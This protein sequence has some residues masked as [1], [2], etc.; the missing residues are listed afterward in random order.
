MNVYLGANAKAQAICFALCLAA[1]LVG[2]IFALLFL[3]KANPIERALTDLFACALIGGA[4]YL[5]VEFIMQGDLSLYGTAAFLIGT[6]I[7]PFSVFKLKK[8]LKKRKSNKEDKKNTLDAKQGKNTRRK[9]RKK[10]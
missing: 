9:A 3:R 7:L 8:T 6:T 5:T 2:G 10:H 4:F 1:G